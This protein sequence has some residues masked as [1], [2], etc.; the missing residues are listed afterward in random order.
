[1]VDICIRTLSLIKSIIGP[2]VN[3][4]WSVPFELEERVVNLRYEMTHIFSFLSY[5]TRSIKD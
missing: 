1:M 4:M 3:S 2:N 5:C